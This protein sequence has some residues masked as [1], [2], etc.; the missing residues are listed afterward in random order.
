VCYNTTTITHREDFLS[1]KIRI[2]WRLKLDSQFTVTKYGR[3]CYAILN[4]KNGLLLRCGSNVDY[5]KPLDDI[6]NKLLLFK[7]K[8]DAQ[9]YID[10]I[11]N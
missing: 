8:A 4:N 9:T 2:L 5:S 6:D 11:E 10:N 1:D 3:W 7:N